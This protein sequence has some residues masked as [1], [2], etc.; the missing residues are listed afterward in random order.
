MSSVF[1]A[2]FP[3]PQISHNY[4]AHV[5]LHLMAI[6]LVILFSLSMVS[7]QTS[8]QKVSCFSVLI[9]NFSYSP[10]KIRKETREI[11]RGNEPSA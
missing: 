3:D 8:T 9:Q 2:P 4:K 10:W 7:C 5:F 6:Y 11:K 1:P